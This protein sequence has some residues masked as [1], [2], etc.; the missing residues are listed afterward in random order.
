MMTSAIRARSLT[1]SRGGRDVLHGL[2]FDVPAGAVTGLLG[3]SGCGKSTLLRAVVGVQA[4]VAGRLDVLGLPAGDPRL[5][6]RVG[7]VTQSP[8]VYADLSVRANL[9]YFADVTR[10]PRSRVDEVLADVD[11]QDAAHQSVGRLSGGQRRGCRSR[12]R[13]S[14][15]L[16]CWCSTSPPSASTRCCGATCGRCSAAWPT[17]AARSS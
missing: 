11:L 13:C 14:P 6:R 16:T 10:A 2:T 15:S 17:T 5:R 9:R 12:R 1:V 7:Y 4:G 8:A 3:P